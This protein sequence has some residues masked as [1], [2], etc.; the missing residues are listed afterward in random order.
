MNRPRRKSNTVLIVDDDVTFGTALR[1]L[2]ASDGHAV[3]QVLDGEEALRRV[4][5]LGSDLDLVLLDL[6]LPKR[7][8]F[9]VAKELVAA[10]CEVPILVMTGVYDDTREIQALRSL[11]VSGWIHKSSPLEHFLF[12]VNGLLCP[13][14]EDTRGSHRVAASM[15]VQFVIDGRTC[16]GASY[17][18]STSGVY[19]RTA[20]PL[21]AGSVIDMALRLPTAEELIHVEAEIV[22]S[23]A[24]EDVRGT[25]YPAGFG[26]RFTQMTQLASAAIKHLVDLVHAEEMTGQLPRVTATRGESVADP[27]RVP[28]QICS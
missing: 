25:A 27:E 24:A 21:P 17:N 1:Q 26:A 20:E 6:L 12:R 15:P 14:R 22:H 16:Y 4:S 9:E 5:A 19:V 2:L 11:G 7:T 13:P 18:L 8:G 10:G 3:H 28:A 23:A